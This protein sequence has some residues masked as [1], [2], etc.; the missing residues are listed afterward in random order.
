ME[1]ILVSYPR[2]RRVFVDGEQCGFTN[3]VIQIDGGTHRIDLGEPANYTPQFRRPDISGTAVFDPLLL[4]FDL[5][6]A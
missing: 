6:M 1:F 2:R 3:E 4:E 5:V